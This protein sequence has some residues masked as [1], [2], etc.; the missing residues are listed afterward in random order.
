MEGVRCQTGRCVTPVRGA[1]ALYTSSMVFDSLCT[2]ST[3]PP[4]ADVGRRGGGE[5]GR[6]DLRAP[7]AG[8]CF[9]YRE[10]TVRDGQDLREGQPCAGEQGGKLGCGA[11]LAPVGH[12]HF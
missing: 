9:D 6:R 5:A 4:G 3:L 10:E 1:C 12:Q 11:F 2:P 7:S 8:R